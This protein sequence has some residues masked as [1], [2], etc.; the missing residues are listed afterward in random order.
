MCAAIA[1]PLGSWVSCAGKVRCD[2]CPVGSNCP[3]VTTSLL[4]PA[5]SFCPARS[6]QPTRCPAGYFCYVGC[7]VSALCPAGFFCPA[8]SS[9]PQ[10]C[11]SATTTGRSVCPARRS[12]DSEQAEPVDAVRGGGAERTLL[13]LVGGG[14]DGAPA[15]AAPQQGGVDSMTAAGYSLAA[16]LASGL[17]VRRVLRHCADAGTAAPPVK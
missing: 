1:C 3:T 2:D 7:K 10:R 15:A 4:C 16:L 13:A 9:N 17:A 8:G 5:G 6:S 12:L 11:P 14:S